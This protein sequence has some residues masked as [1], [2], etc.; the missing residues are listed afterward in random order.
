[1]LVTILSLYEYL[2][3]NLETENINLSYR[4]NTN[5]E[6]IEVEGLVIA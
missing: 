5:G 6:D 3:L 1:M 4:R 2:K